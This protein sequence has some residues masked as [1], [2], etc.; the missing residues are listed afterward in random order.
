VKTLDMIAV[1][2]VIVGA[3][4]WGLVG[5]LR[6]DVVAAIFGMTFGQVSGLTAV[7]YALVGLAG[8]WLAVSALRARSHAIA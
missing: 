6:L 8:L 4:N 5:L 3:V 2:L 7:V 1:V